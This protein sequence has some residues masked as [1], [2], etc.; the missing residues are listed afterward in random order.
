MAEE[1]K[2]NNVDFTGIDNLN[3]YYDLEL[4]KSRIKSLG[5]FDFQNIDLR[6]KESLN[7][8]FLEN[9][10][11]HIINLAAQA[12]VRYS[13]TNPDTYIENNVQGFVNLLECCRNHSVEHLI[14][15]ST[16]SVYGLNSNM[17]LDSSK[18]CSHPMSLYAA[19]KK[20]NE[21]SAHTYSHLFNIPTTGLRFFTVYGPYGRPDM[22]LF[23]FVDA[24]LNNKSIKVFNKGEMVRDFTYVKD[25][26]K[27]IFLLL[28]HPPKENPDWDSKFPIQDTSSAPYRILNIGNSKPVEL[29]TYIKII[30]K[31]L[32]RKAKKELLPMQP[33]DVI[34]TQSN[35]DPLYDLIKY[36]PQTTVETGIKEFISWFREYYNK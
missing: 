27:S 13:L 26:V 4:K 8:L 15:A 19:S 2:S 17:P 30:E 25:I 20:M 14:Y 3:N 11:T 36:R 6:N 18:A 32:N 35:S 23:L 24:I 22:A 16:S 29:S 10:F 1:L 28:G 31:E 12:G 5:D 7:N 9:K 34:M 33:G 21:L